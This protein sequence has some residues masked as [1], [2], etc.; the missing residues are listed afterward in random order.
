ME[1]VGMTRELNLKWVRNKLIHNRGRELSG[2]FNLLVVGEL[3]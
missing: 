2:T 1:P 3:F